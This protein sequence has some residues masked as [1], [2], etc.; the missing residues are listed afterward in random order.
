MSRRFSPDSTSTALGLPM[1]ASKFIAPREHCSHTSLK[2]TTLTSLVGAHHTRT[3]CPNTLTEGSRSTGPSLIVHESILPYS[4]GVFSALWAWQGY[5]FLKDYQRR[6]REIYISPSAA[7]NVEDRLSTAG[8][9]DV[10]PG[11]SKSTMRT[12]LPRYVLH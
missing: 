11:T 4:R 2:S 6:H 9:F 3:G 12:K 5:S 7:R 8:T 10:L 1:M